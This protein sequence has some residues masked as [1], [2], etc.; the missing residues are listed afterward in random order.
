MPPESATQPTLAKAATSAPVGLGRLLDQD[1]TLPSALA[2]QSRALV[3]QNMRVCDRRWRALSSD[4]AA[5]ED[6][7]FWH[8][9]ADA[10]EADNAH[11]L[12]GLRRRP[13]E[14]HHRGL[15][16]SKASARSTAY[17]GAR[18]RRGRR[19]RSGELC[20]PIAGL[21]CRSHDCHQLLR[22]TIRLRHAYLATKVEPCSGT[23]GETCPG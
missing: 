23:G 12:G 16:V 4:P 21:D 5:G 17:G 13:R 15:R 18:H 11:R 8:S 19:P 22:R 9:P 3:R 1:R 7:C 10:Q 20:R 6:Y 14:D 2:L